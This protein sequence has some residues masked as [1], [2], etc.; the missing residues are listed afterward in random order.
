[1]TFNVLRNRAGNVMNRNYVKQP[2]GYRNT[3]NGFQERISHWK[4]DTD[5]K[6]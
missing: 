6:K 2:D 3:G 1:M 4:E 5:I